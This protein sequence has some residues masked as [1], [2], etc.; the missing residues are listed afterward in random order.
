MLGSQFVGEVLGGMALLEGAY[1]WGWNFGFQKPTPF[2]AAL[3]FL[4]LEDQM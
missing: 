1:H 2:L 3:L 4:L